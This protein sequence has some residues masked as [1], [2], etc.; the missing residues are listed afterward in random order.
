VLVAIGALVATSQL[1]CSEDTTQPPITAVD[2]CAGEGGSLPS[3]TICTWAGTGV[4]AFNG[5]GRPLLETSFYWPIDLTYH[6]GTFYLVDWNN[7]VIRM[8]T[9]QGTVQTLLGSGYPG[10]GPVNPADTAIELSPPGYPSREVNLNHPTHILVLP[11]GTLLLSAWHNHKLRHYDPAT[12][13][14]YVRCGSTYGYSG[15]GGQAHQAQ[16]NQPLQTALGPDGGLYVLDMRNERIRRIDPDG[17]ITTVVGTG[18]PGY[19]GDGGPP[20]QAQIHLPN[21][22]NPWPGGSVLFDPQGR[23][24]ISDALNNCIRRVDFDLNVIETFAGTGVP[25]FSGDGGPAT[26]AQLRYPRDLL[27]HDGKLYVAD[28][29]NHRIRVID[30]AT[31]IISTFAGNGSPAFS[32]DGGPAREASLNRPAGLEYAEGYIYIADTLNSR[33]RRVKL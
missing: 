5:D 14:M 2:A 27:L 24:Y 1:G 29:E 26:A 4:Q 7:E 17:I 20:D 32:G 19:S 11:D 22:T 25:G 3:G 8:T 6:N 31:G 15:D 28:E 33:Y 21:S 10:D 30:M 13:L 9:A 18:E 16:L 23:L 12:G